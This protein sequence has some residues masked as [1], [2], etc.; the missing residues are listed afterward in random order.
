V[1]VIARLPGSRMPVAV[2]RV[3]GAQLPLKFTLDD[4]LAMNPASLIS[5]AREVEIEARISRSGLAMPEAG[6]LISS[7]QTIPVGTRGVTLN[8]A[9]VRP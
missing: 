6:D 9:Q 8:V 7:V 1:M 4:S 3:R 5:S 2:L